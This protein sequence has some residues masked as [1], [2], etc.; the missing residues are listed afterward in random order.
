LVH[1]DE[2]RHLTWEDSDHIRPSSSNR[3]RSPR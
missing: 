1:L 3:F 2:N